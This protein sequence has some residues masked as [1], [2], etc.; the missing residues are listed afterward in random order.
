LGKAT[1]WGRHF[2]RSEKWQSQF[3]EVWPRKSAK[4]SEADNPV[5][6]AFIPPILLK[7]NNMRTSFIALFLLGLLQLSCTKK[8]DLNTATFQ[9]KIIKEVCNDAIVQLTDTSYKQYAENGFAFEGQ[10]YD[11]VF[12]TR[13]SCVEY[14]NLNLL[15]WLDYNL[16]VA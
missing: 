12:F 9:V 11:H 5:K 13:F 15:K 8:D 14:T 2:E 3:H 1:I 7:K 16:R 4:Q 10:N 6:A